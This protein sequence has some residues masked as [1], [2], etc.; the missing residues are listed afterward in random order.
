MVLILI[1]LRL[2]FNESSNV[3]R[4]TTMIKN[5][6]FTQLKLDIIIHIRRRRLYDITLNN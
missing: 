6:E 3:R 1:H 4:I 5:V 2:L